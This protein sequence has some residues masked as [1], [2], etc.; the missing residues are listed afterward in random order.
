M[1]E[2][3]QS[4]IGIIEDEAQKFPPTWE[5]EDGCTEQRRAAYSR[6]RAL[7]DEFSPF[8]ICWASD[9]VDRYVHTAVL[10]V[11]HGTN[12][13]KARSICDT[14]LTFF[15]KHF[16][17]DQVNPGMST[18]HGYFGSGIYITTSARYAADIYSN[19]ALLMC[20]ASMR[21]SFPVVANFDGSSPVHKP[22]DV[23]KLEGKEIYKAYNAHFIP[24]RSVSPGDPQCTVYYPCGPTESSST[25][26]IVLKNSVQT[27]PRFWIELQVDLPSAPSIQ[28]IPSFQLPGAG[29]N[30]KG[31]CENVH[32]VAYGQFVCIKKQFGKFAMPETLYSGSCGVCK[33]SV[34]SRLSFFFYECMYS[35]KGMY[36]TGSQTQKIEEQNLVA[37][38]TQQA[39]LP[40]RHWVY[41][42]IITKQLL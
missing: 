37:A 24:V 39:T 22:S 2:S 10:P 3:F 25:E 28:H 31:V 5:Q 26:E 33:E 12:E 15:G 18:D 40:D 19:G 6:W 17:W 16:Y 14:G 8:S 11:W 29:L 27:F 7:K 32:C 1:Q 35:Y 30:L 38:P 34:S 4:Y 20:W 42:N 21:S 36:K 9:K 23:V 41:L 13:V